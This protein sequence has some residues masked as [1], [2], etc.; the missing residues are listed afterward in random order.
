MRDEYADEIVFEAEVTPHRSLS[1]RGLRLV[2]GF[3]CTVSLCSTTLFWSLGA[4]P[5]A[6]FN[7]GEILLAMVLLRMHARSAKQRELLLLTGN[8]L[9]I[10]RT[11]ASGHDTERS[12]APGWLNVVLEER[13]GRV[14]G[15]YL[16]SRGRVVEV[17]RALGEPEKRD[18]AEALKEA[19][20]RLRNPEF[21]NPQLRAEAT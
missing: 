19:V 9:R 16:S 1:P 3:V 15:L 13:P 10:L 4:W 18:L 2:I 14:P 21:D 5:I 11:D 20:H 6:G 8:S 12:L 7:G 17:G